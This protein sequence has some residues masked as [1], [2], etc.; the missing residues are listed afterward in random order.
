VVQGCFGDLAKAVIDVEKRI[1]A[2]G[3]EFRGGAHD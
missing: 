1:M 2:I 3:G